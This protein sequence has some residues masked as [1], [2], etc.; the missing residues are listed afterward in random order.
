[1][2][3]ATQ[4]FLVLFLVPMVLTEIGRWLYVAAYPYPKVPDEPH[5]KNLDEFVAGPGSRPKQFY[6]WRH[7]RRTLRWRRHN[8]LKAWVAGFMSLYMLMLV[9]MPL[10]SWW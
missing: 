5:L 1:M 3:V 2:S 9:T 4:A 6:E 7:W 10:W 8:E